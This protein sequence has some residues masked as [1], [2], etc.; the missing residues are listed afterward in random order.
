MKAIIK[1]I[2][3]ALWSWLKK[4]LTGP[5]KSPAEIQKEKDDE[6]WQKFEDEKNEII[7][8]KLPIARASNDAALYNKL[9]DRL[10]RIDREQYKLR[11]RV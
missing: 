8:R 4:K 3:D 6:Q 10:R 1:I 9:C 5:E 2:I 7:D 11:P